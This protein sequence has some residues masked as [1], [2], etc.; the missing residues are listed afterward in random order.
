MRS[1]LV[2]PGVPKGTP[3]VMMMRCPGWAK[4]SAKAMRQA[5]ATM[6]S[7][8]FGSPVST[9]CS[10]QTMAS[11]R[12]VA[13]I[14]VRAMIGCGGGTLATMLHR[15]GVTV[16]I[17]DIDSWSFRLARQWVDEFVIVDTDEVCA[18]IK[19]VFED[20][21]SILEPAGALAIAGAKAWVAKRGARG[22]RRRSG[23]RRHEGFDAPV[24]SGGERRLSSSTVHPARNTRRATGSRSRRCV[25]SPTAVRPASS[26]ERPPMKSCAG[27]PVSREQI[28][29]QVWKQDFDAS[30]NIVDVYINY[31]RKKVDVSGEP[32]LVQTVRG[33]GYMLKG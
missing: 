9:Q 24:R 26:A 13:G 23:F 15:T 8:S 5:L 6:S 33:V 30:T 21:R 4:P 10:P 25:T 12:P 14:G 1:M 2:A 18:A 27:R 28:S 17:A 19:D 3:A 11:L 32:S 22:D 29:Q 31:V 16:T 7:R 20:T